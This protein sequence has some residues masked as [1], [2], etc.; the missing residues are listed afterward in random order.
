VTIDN[1]CQQKLIDALKADGLID[2]ANFSVRLEDGK[3][4]VNGKDVD[5]SK[6]KDL[7]EKGMKMDLKVEGK[8][9]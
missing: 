7:I 9:Q 6:Y 4:T 3:L 1:P 2:G 5:A 8:L